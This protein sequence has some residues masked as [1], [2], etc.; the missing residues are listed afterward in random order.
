MHA[1]ALGLLGMPDTSPLVGELEPGEFR[2]IDGP[3]ACIPERAIGR[4]AR[5]A[6]GRL[7]PYQ[8]GICLLL[9]VLLSAAGDRAGRHD[10][11]GEARARL[12]ARHGPVRED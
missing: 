1:L 2:W 12:S 10:Q 11:R 8:R 9:A 4:G 6:I 7:G 5:L 3:Q